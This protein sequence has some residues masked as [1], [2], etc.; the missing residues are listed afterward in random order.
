MV[1][2]GLQHWNCV[3][4]AC[5]I[6][7]VL[8]TTILWPSSKYK[9]VGSCCSHGRPTAAPRPRPRAK[10]TFPSKRAALYWH[11]DPGPERNSATRLGGNGRDWSILEPVRFAQYQ[12][13]SGPTHS[14]TLENSSSTSRQPLVYVMIFLAFD[15]PATHFYSPWNRKPLPN[16]RQL[17]R[18]TTKDPPR[19]RQQL[20][21]NGQNF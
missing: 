10:V 15:S 4:W 1:V 3:S 8:Q 20:A 17:P 16:T 9:L 7:T 12:S 13:R 21:L 18:H 5:L 14:G 6:P 11:G 19:T 2:V